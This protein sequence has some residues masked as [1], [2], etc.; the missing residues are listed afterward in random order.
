M[1]G[2]SVLS[3]L[4]LGSALGKA[5]ASFLV[6]RLGINFYSASLG[7]PTFSQDLALAKSFDLLD[8]ALTLIFTITNFIFLHYFLKSKNKFVNIAS[9][10]F[11]FIL[12][13]QVH[14]AAYNLLHIL[15]FLSCFHFLL[16]ITTKT[17][18]KLKDISN[19]T[20]ENLILITNGI[21]CGFYLLLVINQFTTTILPLT[22]LVLTPI[23]YLLFQH[24]ILKK[25]KHT[26]FNF[27]F[28]FFFNYFFFLLFL[29]KIGI[30]YLNSCI[31]QPLSY[32]LFITRFTRLG[33]L[34][35]WRKAFGW[36]GLRA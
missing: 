3:S 19:L 17:R 23:L 16:I 28:F 8:F 33:T 22:A 21:L 2:I 27:F 25:K 12:F 13:L 31:P 34:T 10:I 20:S 1:L 26:I 11:N 32:L 6:Y 24:K 36:A 4:L 15:I 7:I 18:L 35:Q 5:I 9:L 14:F 29:S 30:F